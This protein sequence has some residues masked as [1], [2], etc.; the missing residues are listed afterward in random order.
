MPGKAKLSWWKHCNKAII[1]IKKLYFLLSR[2]VP[3][4]R[5]LYNRF[6]LMTASFPALS[7][8]SRKWLNK[9]IITFSPKQK[10]VIEAIYKGASRE[11]TSVFCQ[12][13]PLGSFSTRLK[14]FEGNFRI[15]APFE[16]AFTHYIM[17]NWKP[18]LLLRYW[19]ILSIE[20]LCEWHRSRVLHRRRLVG[21][22][23]NWFDYS[24]TK[25]Q[26]FWS[27]FFSFP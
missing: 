22:G 23:W 2:N 7:I 19:K 10:C 5:I 11:Y 12:N 8:N 1:L 13:P 18:F 3:S 21:T 27:N 9:L 6:F 14:H 24:S 16:R 4:N 26:I 15:A 20:C 25:E 17:R